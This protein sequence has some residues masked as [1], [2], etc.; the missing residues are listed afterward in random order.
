MSRLPSDALDLA[1]RVGVTIKKTWQKREPKHLE[2][3]PKPDPDFYTGP[4]FW[5]ICTLA[6][7]FLC[8]VS[9]YA[10]GTAP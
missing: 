6:I 9:C 2:P 8:A 7:V 10:F 5:T 4:V 3:L 1:D